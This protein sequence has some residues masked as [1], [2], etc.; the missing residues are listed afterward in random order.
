MGYIIGMDGGG[1]KTRCA[2]SAPSGEIVYKTNGG[3][4]N[5]L[6][7]GTEKVSENIFNLIE[8]CRDNLKIDHSVISAVLLG[9]AGAGRKKHAQ[10]LE[11]DFNSYCLKKNIKIFFFHVESD[12]R[13]ALEGAFSGGPGCI[14]I[15][16]TGSIIL[17]KDDAGNILRAGG[18]GR[19]I[20][21]EGGGY[22]TGRKAL[23]AVS[24]SFD[25]RAE[26]T[27][28]K[29]LLETNFGIN[30]PDT[31]ITEVYEKNFDIAAVAPFVLQ[32]AKQGDAAAVKIIDEETDELLLLVSSM[33]KRMSKNRIK[34]SLIGGLID[35]ENYFANKLRQKIS[36][37]FSEVELHKPDF[38]PEVGAVLLARELLKLNS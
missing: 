25:N 22:S 34:L 30:S 11:E 4:A 29:K 23:Q 21:D 26:G 19:L 1:T 18:F 9:T 6:I 27:L 2:V 15:A 7:H 24:K 32:A 17:G 16:G 5:F 8:D 10:K 13:I 20:G 36:S 35:K 3:S 12:A 37:V 31:L 14:L 38:A 33:L 28:L